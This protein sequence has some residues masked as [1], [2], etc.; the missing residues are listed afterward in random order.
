MYIYF[1]TKNYGGAY[2]T[3][4]NPQSA[5]EVNQVQN[6]GVSRDVHTAL[7]KHTDLTIS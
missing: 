6:G 5:C 3:Y 2:K 1:A 7:F 4:L